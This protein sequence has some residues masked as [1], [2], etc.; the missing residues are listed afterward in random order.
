VT[1]RERQRLTDVQA[2]IEAIRSHLQRGNLS[3]GLIFDAVRRAPSR[4]TCPTS[5]GRSA[6]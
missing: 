6:T 2:A 5:N 3:D 1:Y 4:R